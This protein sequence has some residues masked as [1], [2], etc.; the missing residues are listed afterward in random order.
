MTVV[1]ASVLVT[2]L[3]DDAA[4]GDAARA[5]LLLAEELAAPEL[6]DLEVLSVLRRQQHRGLLDQRRAQLALADLI[7]FPLVRY[8]HLDL[9]ERVWELRD[10]LT[11][12]DAS[13]V[14][15][16]ELLDCP[17]VTADGKL[18]KGAAH[19]RSPIAVDV[20]G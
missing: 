8:S 18:A 4:D 11:P 17:L 6:V 5:R 19:A 1:D 13:Y 3:A 10:A 2:A 20:L 14:A 7:A 9:A 12:Y 15:L 16:A